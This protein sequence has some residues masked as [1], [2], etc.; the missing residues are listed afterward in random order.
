MSANSGASLKIL[1]V[2]DEEPVRL[3]LEAILVLSGHRVGLASDGLTACTRFHAERWD[4]VLTDRQM[5]NMGGEELAA[6]LKAHSPG[7]PV[8]LVTGAPPLESC[9]DIDA[10]VVKPFS[11]ETILEAID[12][13]VRSTLSATLDAMTVELLPLP[14]LVSLGASDLN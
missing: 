8:I 12:E 9:A 1:V 6:L 7:I 4:V 3:I 14:A 11:L 2:D 13:C 5:P 10:I